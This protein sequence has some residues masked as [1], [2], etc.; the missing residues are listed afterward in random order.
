[1]T[2]VREKCEDLVSRHRAPKQV[3]LEFGAPSPFQNF[4]LPSGLYALPGYGH[5]KV[6]TQASHRTNDRHRVTSLSKVAYEAL[7][8][9]DSIKWK[10]PQ[11]AQRGIASPEI[12]H[13]NLDADVVQLV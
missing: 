12:V 4:K 7:I 11:I 13:G 2:Q 10:A 9:L 5:T 8:D 6:I 3:A 1:M